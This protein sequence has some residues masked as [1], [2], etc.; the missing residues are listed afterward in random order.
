M[1]ALAGIFCLIFLSACESDSVRGGDTDAASPEREDASAAAMVVDNL[2]PLSEP[3]SLGPYEAAW[4][5]TVDVEAL[6]GLSTDDVLDD[7]LQLPE[8]G[9]VSLRVGDSESGRRHVLRGEARVENGQGGSFTFSM[10]EDRVEG[11]FRLQRRHYHLRPHEDG[12]ALFRVD[13]D[14]R[15]DPHP[16]GGPM[17]PD[18]PDAEPESDGAY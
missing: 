6:R 14:R 3:E 1:R 12:H 4:R 15:P 13:E 9:R 16:P 2:E 17:E 10:R 11:Q 8:L 7:F 18:E 5:V